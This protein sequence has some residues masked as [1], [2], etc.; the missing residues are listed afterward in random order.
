M[1][2]F[3]RLS[4]FR[5]PVWLRFC[6]FIRN[7]WLIWDPLIILMTLVTFK[8]SS[9]GR[10]ITELVPGDRD[11]RA[12]TDWSKTKRFGPVM[13]VDNWTIF[14]I[15]FPSFY[16]KWKFSGSILW[17]ILHAYDYNL[18]ST[19]LGLLKINDT[20]IKSKIFVKKFET[21]RCLDCWY[22]FRLLIAVDGPWKSKLIWIIF[23]SLWLTRT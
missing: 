7:L 20:H 14:N 3:I 18:Q 16:S 11:L 13:D 5:I 15:T 10:S 1:T 19:I 23:G 9:R 22:S 12:K 17:T 21:S 4:L 8:L 2:F 6:C